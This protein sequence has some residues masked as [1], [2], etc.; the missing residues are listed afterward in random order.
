MSYQPVMPFKIF[1]SLGQ[2]LATAAVITGI[3]MAS[4]GVT[5][6]LTSAGETRRQIGTALAQ[7]ANISGDEITN[8]AASV[9]E[10]DPYRTE[11]YTEIKNLLSDIDHDMSAVDMSCTGT[12]NLNRLPRNVRG[13]V[14]TIIVEYCNQASNIVERNGL[15]VRQFNAITAAYPQDPGLAEQI[16]T[17]LIQIQQQSMP[18][19]EAAPVE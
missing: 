13:Q 18:E 2:S 4:T 7:E 8:Y 1:W 6:P 3:S 19:N 17:A 12:A 5:L 16:R 10:M 9:L 15:T 14:R 11:A